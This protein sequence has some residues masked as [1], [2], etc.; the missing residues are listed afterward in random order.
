MPSIGIMMYSLQFSYAKLTVS[1][2]SDKNG[3][4]WQNQ[5]GL[6]LLIRKL[7]F[8]DMVALK[9]DRRYNKCL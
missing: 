1:M 9:R 4:A 7:S 8:I 5:I 3:L 6:P 2:A